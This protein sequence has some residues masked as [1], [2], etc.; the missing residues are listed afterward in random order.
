VAVVGIQQ[1]VID[2]RGQI[3]EVPIR[4]RL[5]RLHDQLLRGWITPKPPWLRRYTTWIWSVSRSRNT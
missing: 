4:P 5:C 2:Q 1:G 3:G